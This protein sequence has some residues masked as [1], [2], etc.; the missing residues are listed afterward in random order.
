M[1]RVGM[2]QDNVSSRTTPLPPSP[3]LGRRRLRTEKS[4]VREWRLPPP[5]QTPDRQVQTLILCPRL[6]RQPQT[7]AIE[8]FAPVS[9]W[10]RF[11]TE[12]EAC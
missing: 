2:A 4:S 12:L 7:K 11:P 3:N 8:H 6:I 5:P 1:S 9:Y 10:T